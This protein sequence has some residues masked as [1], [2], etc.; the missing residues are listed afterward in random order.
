MI[1]E[2]KTGSR[3]FLSTSTALEVLANALEIGARKGVSVSVAVVGPSLE[4][5]AFARADNAT[6]HSAETSRRK[7]Q[8]AVSTRRATGWMSPGL[9]V[10]L[11][12]ASGALLTNIAGGVPIKVDGIVVAGLGIAGG[13]VEQDAEIAADVLAA[14][15][16][17]AL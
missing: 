13:T 12:M 14:I 10:E 9:A 8:T 15:R 7:A 3:Q 6:P 2:I 1:I 11:P 17:D 5:T 16:A 4:L